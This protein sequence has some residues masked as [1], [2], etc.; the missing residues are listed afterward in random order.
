MNYDHFAE[1]NTSQSDFAMQYASTRSTSTK[2]NAASKRWCISV[3]FIFVGIPA[4]LFFVALGG[5]YALL[6]PFVILTGIQAVK[7]RHGWQVFGFITGGGFLFLG[8]TTFLLPG[9]AGIF[10]QIGG[11]AVLLLGLG[12]LVFTPLEMR[13]TF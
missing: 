12:Y 7:K 2:P 1:N 11:I 9:K 6:G 5:I 3:L 4:L 8:A 10:G 13:R